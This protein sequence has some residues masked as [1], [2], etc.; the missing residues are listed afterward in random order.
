M[1]NF[2]K[3]VELFSA[4]LDGTLVGKPDAT[5][6][7]KKTW[8]KIPDEKRPLLCYNSG[9]LLKHALEVLETSGLPEPDYLICGVGTL[10]YD[11]KQKEVLKE[12]ADTLTVGW[13]LKKV[14]EVIERHPEV[15]R[16]P[17]KY[18]N[19][20]KSSWHYIGASPEDIEALRRE[21]EEAGLKVN[22]V[23]SSS[24]D[25]DILP[26]YANKG[27]SLKWL[28]NHL[29]IPPSRVLVA[30]DTGNDSSMFEI[31]GVRGIIVG[32]AQPEL[33]RA[34]VGKATFVSEKPA[35]DGVLEGLLHFGVIKRIEEVSK[36]EVQHKS[37]DPSLRHVLRTSLFESLNQ[38][39]LT[40]IEEAYNKAIE[41]LKKNI[42]P[43]GFSACSL[44]D[45]RFH[46][47]DQNYKSVWA[48]DGAITVIGSLS[49]DDPEIKKCQQET[50]LTLLR[51]VSPY[52]LVPSNVSIEDETPDYSGIGGIASVDGGLWL[53]IAFYQYIR[54]IRDYNFLREWFDVLQLIIHRISAL[55]SNNDSLIE[56]PEAGDWTD[57]FGRSYNVLYDEVL[58]YYANLC[59]ARMAELI[60]KYQKA[61][62]HFQWTQNIKESI[63]LKFWPT[64]R[65]EDL[66]RSFA[67]Q[68]F[69]MGETSYLLAEITPFSFDWRCDVYGN[70]L[71]AIFNV[72]DLDRSRIA[73]RF[74]WG[75][76][77]NDPW[78]VANLYPPVNVGDPK[79]RN[80]Y[81]VNLLNLPHH[82]HNGG[83]W[84][85]IGAEWVRF[86]NR[87]GLKDIAQRE[88]YRL[89]HLNKA[90]VTHEWEFNEWVHGIT[91]RPMGKAF[92]AWSASGF[93]QAYNELHMDS[94]YSARNEIP[95]RN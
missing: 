40:F 2:T 60:G 72:L 44:K 23:Y 91:G 74:M 39:E 59:F 89:A 46:S 12:F 38:E 19:R 58:W 34:T 27:N 16:Q 73:F 51:N 33:H 24:R 32:N 79:W 50:L 4:D 92:Q 69:T 52:G 20:F 86:I 68:Q 18:Q 1:R 31:K 36:N 78:P 11:Y 57:L 76:G 14:E 71:A 30:G 66:V 21:L 82:Y 54:Y 81:T 49:I 90:G 37:Y 88:L 47:T 63:L 8:E 53:I 83:I 17:R 64:I 55:D 5:L 3:E 84:P 29:G 48:R 43:L 35:A 7:F 25:L 15:T 10:I 13:D 9:R 61:S 22:V 41:A 70:I 26:E 6:A 80:Y 93:I 56:I 42:T 85:F 62:E 94:F 67:D 28:L 45:N 65:T 75:A 95:H 87:L 77:V